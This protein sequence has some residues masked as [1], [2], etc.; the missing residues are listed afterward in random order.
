MFNLLNRYS[1][2]LPIYESSAAQAN[3]VAPKCPFFFFNQIN[4]PQPWL[5][6]RVV[7]FCDLPH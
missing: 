2:Y 7:A 5:L 3:N 6:K 1:I 4:D